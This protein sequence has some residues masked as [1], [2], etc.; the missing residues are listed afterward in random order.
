MRITNQ[1]GSLSGSIFLACL[2]ILCGSSLVWAQD[3]PDKIVR[4]QILSNKKKRTFYLYV[5][6]S[7]KTKAPLIVLL[8]GSGHV[9]LSLVEK[10]KDLANKEGFIVVGPDADGSGWSTPR[11][12]P[13][14]LHDLVEELKSKYPINPRRVYLFGHSAGAVFALI[15][16]TVESEYFTATAIHAGAFRTPE[17]YKTISS[18][19]RKIPLAIWVGTVDPFFP[20]TDVRATRDAFRSQ[21]FTIEVSEMPGH[22]HWYYDLAPDINQKAWDFLK[23]Y[24]LPSEPKYSILATRDVA[25]SANKYVQDINE[26]SAQARNLLR[27]SN[28]KEQ[29]VAGRDFVNERAQINRIAREHIEILN[30]SIALWRAAAEKANSASQL[31]LS[32]K[33]KQYFNLIA[34]SYEKC[35]AMLEAIRA[36]PEA[37]LSNES[38]EVIE[39]RRDEA[40]KRADKL[41][42][43][44]DE[45]EKAI[46]ELMR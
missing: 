26:I 15:M 23:K 20:L 43:E 13:E 28:E 10:W 16:S 22:D 4:E 5:P 38:R 37:L 7:I 11:D 34:Q 14:F 32:D 39:G 45:L 35:A 6:S 30:E 2:L 24:E 27:R 42:L 8:H 1:Q 19:T 44:I 18:A 3:K 12:G 40:Q 36:R 31:R 9:G 25:G 33:H 21:G 29:E 46:A 41:H 17:E